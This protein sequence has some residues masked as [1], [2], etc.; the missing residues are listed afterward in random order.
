MALSRQH[1]FVTGET[2]TASL[3]NAE[4]DNIL[5][6]AAALISP[7]PSGLDLNGNIL[8][9]DADA[10]S[11][12]RESADDVVVFRLQGFDAL[13]LDGDVSTPVN[14]ITFT[15]AAT[16]VAPALTAHGETNVALTLAGKGTGAVQLGQATSVGVTLAADQPIL[17][18]SANEFVKFVKTASA[19]N[20]F[21]IANA[22]TAGAP[23]LSATGGDSN[24]DV[25]LTPKGAG[26][27]KIAAGANAGTGLLITATDAGA[28][29]GPTL[30]LYRDSASPAASDVLGEIQFNGR[31]SAANKQL[32]AR[33]K[34]TITDATSTSE[35]STLVASTVV[36]GAETTVLTLTA[37]A[38]LGAPTGG[39]K[40]AG[41]LNLAA[42]AAATALQQNGSPAG[43]PL[44]QILT[45][46]TSASLNFTGANN[47][48]YRGYLCVF[49]RLL[50]ATDSVH[51]LWRAS[52]D[53]GST[54]RSGSEYVG[55]NFSFNSRPEAAAS[56]AGGTSVLI[57]GQLDNAA[58][59]L[60]G[61]AQVIL[62][63]SAN[64]A[65]LTWN[66]GGINSDGS[67]AI[68]YI[69]WGQN[70][71]ASVNGFG[72]LM[73]SGNITSGTI[74]IYGLPKV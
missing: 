10:D 51:L 53:Q 19:V 47:T 70:N 30:D 43:L 64:D 54:L 32:Y 24:I 17:D 7:L 55:A 42:N 31:D 36:A 65:Q 8:T 5:N 68:G 40:G 25:Q 9:I 3:L 44:L 48:L 50:P 22:A 74:Y 18:S 12:L 1:T 33:L 15:S 23:T 28:G 56:N 69:G 73:S 61:F 6:N 45:A 2:L 58:I 49:H 71:Q 11:T 34:A 27:V 67:T 66:V 29:A 57:A 46:S 20:E 26:Q 14:G 13:I 62:G 21:T 59:G 38:Q 72:F 52:T 37:G 39:D 63:A 35:D 4:F 60:G 16:G 41:T